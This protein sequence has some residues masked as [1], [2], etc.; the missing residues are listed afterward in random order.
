MS[1]T[2]EGPSQP[3]WPGL[4]HKGLH[5]VA[6]GFSEVWF[7]QA[8]SQFA[9]KRVTTSL[10]NFHHCVASLPQDVATCLIHLV[11][12]TPEDPYA[13]LTACLVQM[14]TLSNFQRHQTLQSTFKN[15]C[16]ILDFNIYQSV[17]P[18]FVTTHSS[19]SNLFWGDC[20]RNFKVR[21]TQRNPNNLRLSKNSLDKYSCFTI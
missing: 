18:L 1:T 13:T 16:C 15:S 19:I 14:Y 21:L 20:R 9:I 3:W 6:H 2:E 11:R 12:N 10:T 7:L 17:G 5:Q 4:P 8:E